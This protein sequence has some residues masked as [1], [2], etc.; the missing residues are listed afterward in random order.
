MYGL[1]HRDLKPENIL[2][3]DS[4]DMLPEI[5]L[6]DFGTAKKFKYHDFGD[7]S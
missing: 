1:V 4:D 6:I 5:K 2:L 7:S 3:A